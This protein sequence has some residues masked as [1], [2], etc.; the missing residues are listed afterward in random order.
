[1][2]LA[3]SA[4]LKPGVM[5][6]ARSRS[7]SRSQLDALAVD[8]EDLHPADEVGVADLDLP[9]ETARAQQGLVEH[10]GPVGGRHDD[11]RPVGCRC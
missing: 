7:K 5:R 10:L 3:R 1:M 9:V 11:H 6:A 8:L 4:P 2:A